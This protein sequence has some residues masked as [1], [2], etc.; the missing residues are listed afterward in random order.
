MG[1]DPQGSPPLPPPLKHC[2]RGKRGRGGRG[3][4]G[5]EGE[6][7][8]GGRE[9]TPIVIPEC[10]PYENMTTIPHGNDDDHT[11]QK[12]QIEMFTTWSSLSS[13]P[14]PTI[15]FLS[16]LEKKLKTKKN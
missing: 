7:G 14:S 4:R 11:V 13:S 1:Q 15:M 9:E 2:E 10:K 6:E 16:C 12:L 3:G 5:E 8:R